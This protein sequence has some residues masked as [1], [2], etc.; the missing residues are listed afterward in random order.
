MYDFTRC[1]PVE[2]SFLA[3]INTQGSPEGAHMPQQLFGIMK[4]TELTL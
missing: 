1:F 3:C 4:R 2:F